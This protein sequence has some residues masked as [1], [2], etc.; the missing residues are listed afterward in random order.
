MD[1]EY[2]ENNQVVDRYV[3]GRLSEAEADVF[4]DHYLTC[5]ECLRRLELA[6]KFQRG[7]RQVAAEEATG[8]VGMLAAF[9]RSRRGLLLGS[10][11]VLVLAASALLAA[12]EIRDSRERARIAQVRVDEA[13]Q[14]A[15]AARSRSEEL[16]AR[17]GEEMAR[18]DETLARE[19]AARKEESGTRRMASGAWLVTLVPVRSGP[20]AGEPSQHVALPPT[21][22][23]IVL[24][25]DLDL[26]PGS[27]R[28][29]LE[30]RGGGE[31][32]TGEDLRPS[33]EG[34]LAVGL[35]SSLLAPG[36]YRLRVEQS[37]FP[38]ARFTFR[39]L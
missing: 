3:L 28:A 15:A 4:E 22:Q 5:D 11:A 20:A 33:P 38:L 37:G 34:G 18:L 24:F 25:L 27:Y 2:I 7:F 23:W 29:V 1:H 16:R 14:E 19:R 32:W 21:P 17:M 36:D 39:V 6:E 31:V 30:R 13:R 8:L 10:M 9:L 35:D 12:L 26:E